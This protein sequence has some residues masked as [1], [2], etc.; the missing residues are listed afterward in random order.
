MT[1]NDLLL[2]FLNH[3]RWLTGIFKAFSAGFPC[4]LGNPG[5]VQMQPPN[6]EHEQGI[7]ISGPHLLA[8]GTS[9]LIQLA[10]LGRWDL[11]GIT[12]K[13]RKAREIREQVNILIDSKINSFNSPYESSIEILP[14]MAAYHP[15]FAKVEGNPP[16]S[17]R[18]SYY[19]V[20]GRKVPRHWHSET[21]RRDPEIE[22][23]GVCA[24]THHWVGWRLWGWQVGF[25]FR[26]LTLAGGFRKEF[27]C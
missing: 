23:H 16:T 22:G 21:A 20:S 18:S 2:P 14:N 27:T 4:S 6:P 13:A 10:D 3:Q 19:T 25:T 12:S 17:H 9:K 8:F 15:S 1:L 26:A 5:V 24:S 11:P 7:C